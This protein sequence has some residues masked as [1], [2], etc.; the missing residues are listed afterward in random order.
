MNRKKYIFTCAAL[1][2]GF[3]S[4]CGISLSGRDI[5]KLTADPKISSGVLPN[6]MSW[7]V[8]TNTAEKGFADFS[9]V[10]RHDGDCTASCR[11]ILSSQGRIEGRALQKFL[12][13]NAVAPSYEGYVSYRDDSALFRFEDVMLSRHPSL[14]D[15]LL[16]AVFDIAD[17]LSL[18]ADSL[19]ISTEDMAIVVS[20]DVNVG[21]IS[22]KIKTFSLMIPR[23]RA[24]ND[25]APGIPEEASSLEHK[26]DSVGARRPRIHS[27]E[28]TAD[29]L[30]GVCRIG[31]EYSY[32]RMPK[33]LMAT[34]QFAVMDRMASTFG[35]IAA[36]KLRDALRREAIPFA[37]I[38]FNH[39][40][41]AETAG[42]ES[43]R[44][45]FCTLPEHS[46]AAQR[47]FGEVMRSLEEGE[48]SVSEIS[49]SSFAY[50][51][52]CVRSLSSVVSNSGYVQLCADAFLYGA[53]LSTGKEMCNFCA[54]RVL[55]DSVQL[56]LMKGFAKALIST[57]VDSTSF[58]AAG[59]NDGKVSPKPDFNFSDTLLLPG[60]TPKKM[61]RGADRRESMSGGEIWTWQNGFK[62]YYKRVPG[63]KGLQW[64]MTLNK[65]YALE[66]SL[67]SGEAAFMSDLVGLNSVCGIPCEKMRDILS[68]C[69][70]SYRTD[71]SLY[72]TSVRG[73]L[74]EASNLDLLLKWLG[75]M[76][77][78]S[79]KADED[80]VAQYA[81]NIPVLRQMTQGGRNSRIAAIDS[82]ICSG[83]P[84]S[85]VKMYGNFS[86]ETPSKAASLSDKIFSNIGDGF[87]VLS[88]DVDPS[89]LQKTLSFYAGN[90]PVSGIATKRPSVRFQPVSGWSTTSRM[91]EKESIDI[92]LTAPLPMTA[93]NLCVSS[94]A[95]FML[96][97][98]LKDSL[99]GTGFHTRTVSH[100]ALY[101][102]ERFSVLITLDR[103]PEDGFAYGEVSETELLEVLKRV[104]ESLKSSD[105]PLWTDAALKAYK[106]RL[107]S[108]HKAD[109]ASAE[110]WVETLTLRYGAGR[111]V[112]TKIEDK[113]NA[114][115]LNQIRSLL[116]KL[117]QGSR[118]ELVVSK[119]GGNK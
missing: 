14:A 3:L 36:R 108:E 24:Q 55:Q 25:V 1:A 30:G 86:S 103:I 92:L 85:N 69:G 91:G 42:E 18:R 48:I 109:E 23:R 116:E 29:T 87:L 90:F 34:T 75:G 51:E 31:A 28:I 89:D 118:I 62:V 71:V 63:A 35:D 39:T 115:T 106:Q 32:P 61:K 96:D 67:V 64:G 66:E 56:K 107:V 11:E 78:S 6:G 110:W 74:S 68:A 99:V 41:S 76:F 33:E 81:A 10:L 19:S 111:D 5:P 15:S 37:S 7:F 45:S 117:S 16:L 54:S 26:P 12:T 119:K 17:E 21:D 100:F 104:R 38:N 73:T 59:W 58:F 60:R 97:D 40:S 70:I 57:P 105:S 46:G 53:P 82:L 52:R 95:A 79:R 88:G 72:S 98:A 112:Q 83:N 44:I 114:V 27:S 50:N 94:L 20:G 8:V 9:L 65:G 84:Y 13:S 4:L 43:V 2:F 77:S 93:D 102:Q 101:P 22:S 49:L 47:C 80:A 113:I